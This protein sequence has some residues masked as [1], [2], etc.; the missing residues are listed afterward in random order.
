[1][2]R[3]RCCRVQWR[4]RAGRARFEPLLEVFNLF[5]SDNFVRNWTE[6]NPQYGQPVGQAAGSQYRTIQ[7]GVRTTF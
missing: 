2:R 7:L 5:D 4:V 6:L 3:R 1:M